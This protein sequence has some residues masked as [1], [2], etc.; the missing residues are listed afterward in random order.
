MN[1]IYAFVG[2]RQTPQNILD[3]VFAVAANLGIL[4]YTLRSG[5]AEGV[6]LWAEKGCDYVKGKKEIYIPWK[7]FNNSNSELYNITKEMYELA[8]S[9]HPAWNYLSF[10]AKKLHARNCC[11]VLGADLKTPCDYVICWTK[12]GVEVGGTRTAMVL[13]KKNKIKVY[14]LAIKEDLEKVS[15]LT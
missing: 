12:N 14:N 6:D 10:G 15:K 7:G 3:I 13:A 5:H 1:K 11:Q 8:E 4:G 2:S 9:I